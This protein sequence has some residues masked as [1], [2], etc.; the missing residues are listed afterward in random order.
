[1]LAVTKTTYAE[2]LELNP[3]KSQAIRKYLEDQGLSKD[4]VYR[5][6]NGKALPKLA[7]EIIQGM[8]YDLSLKTKKK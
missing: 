7:I 8:V 3:E 4:Q 2:I 6:K 5:L 1:M